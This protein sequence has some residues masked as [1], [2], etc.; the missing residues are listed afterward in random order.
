M[1]NSDFWKTAKENDG[2]FYADTAYGIQTVEVDEITDD[3]NS[4]G[5]PVVFVTLCEFQ[6]HEEL[7][8]CQLRFAK[9]R[10]PKCI[11]RQCPDARDN[12]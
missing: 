9:G 3:F 2:K 12:E 6:T 7:C 10:K 1:Y 8:G 11:Q 4:C 5:F